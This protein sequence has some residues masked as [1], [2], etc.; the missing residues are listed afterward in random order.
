MKFNLHSS[1]SKEGN[2]RTFHHILTG[3]RDR[4]SLERT[5]S[6]G[7][8]EVRMK[9]KYRSWGTRLAA[10]IAV[11]IAFLLLGQLISFWWMAI[12][13]ATSSAVWMMIW[14]WPERAPAR[15]EDKA[16]RA[17]SRILN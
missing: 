10:F 7:S 15:V 5:H 3:K 13:A 1:Y 16:P 17:H 12:T 9:T 11:A 14:L 4:H 2:G 6:I 8:E